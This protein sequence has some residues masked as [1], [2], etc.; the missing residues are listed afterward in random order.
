LR[1]LA[2]ISSIWRQLVLAVAAM[3]G[4]FVTGVT[5][6]ALGLGALAT[7]VLI[8]PAYVLEL[9]VCTVVH[10][11]G[12]AAVA[13]LLGW[14]VH[15]ISVGPL[16]FF[17]ATKSFRRI[18][19]HVG[20]EGGGAVF[21]TP[22]RIPRSGRRQA[23]IAAGGVTAN[24]VLAAIGLFYV[25]S[26][27][28]FASTHATVSRV[29]SAALAMNS[30]IFATANLLP[31]RSASG[32]LSDGARL[33]ECAFGKPP[34][35]AARHFV[36]LCGQMVDGVATERWD[37]A[38]VR[39]AENFD[40]TLQQNELRD[41]L[42]LNYYFA[43]GDVVRARVFTERCMQSVRPKSPVLLLAHAFLL[44]FVDRNAAAAMKI[45]D[46]L[47]GQYRN[48]FAYWRSLAAALSRSGDNIG[49]REAVAKALACAEMQNTNPDENDRALFE[50]IQHDR[51]LPDIVANGTPA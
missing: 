23:F 5:T 34:G 41:H 7:G 27:A 4:L 38:H 14:R 2:G 3:L 17:P 43:V 39:E 21:A 6:S 50:A 37:A 22:P 24:F 48:M 15:M 25:R 47:P 19:P 45:L 40:G 18:R 8:V 9:G 13:V 32:S 36:W 28:D 26:G 30:I 16:G 1:I 31:F 29:L 42:V 49:A 11:L 46:D 10:E 51:P 44:A 12:H 33:L 20:D 35:I